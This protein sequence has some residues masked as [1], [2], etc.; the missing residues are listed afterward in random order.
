MLF[1][2][3]RWSAKRLA[4]EQDLGDVSPDNVVEKMLRGQKEWNKL[5]W[6]VW[7]ILSNKEKE[8]NGT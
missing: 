1:I 2:C 3:T 7:A 6:Y 4:S 8:M 5:T